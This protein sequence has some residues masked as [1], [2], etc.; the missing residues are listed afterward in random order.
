VLHLFDAKDIVA[1]TLPSCMCRHVVSWH[2]RINEMNE[3]LFINVQTILLT[4]TECLD[5]H[6]FVNG[7]SIVKEGNE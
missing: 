2:A 5:D 7:D 6:T 4:I 1:A 3:L